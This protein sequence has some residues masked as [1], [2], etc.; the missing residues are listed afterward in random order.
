M[1]RVSFIHLDENGN[2]VNSDSDGETG[3]GFLDSYTHNDPAPATSGAWSGNNENTSNTIDTSTQ[4]ED[5]SPTNSPASNN[6][7][8]GA[9]QLADYLNN[10]GSSVR[11][12][13]PQFRERSMVDVELDRGGRKSALIAASGL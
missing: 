1:S 2:R 10:F 13:T 5:M 9:Q 3:S 4:S 6:N 7:N 11:N 8:P 12:I